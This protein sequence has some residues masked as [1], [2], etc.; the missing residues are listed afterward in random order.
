VIPNDPQQQIFNNFFFVRTN[1]FLDNLKFWSRNWRR[2]AKEFSKFSIEMLQRE[3]Q[4]D[5][6]KTLGSKTR[7]NL[8]SVG[9]YKWFA[10]MVEN[11]LLAGEFWRRIWLQCQQVVI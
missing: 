7:E 6:Q 3:R 8:Y 11:L 2:I 5:R 1:F 9:C 10:E 4:T